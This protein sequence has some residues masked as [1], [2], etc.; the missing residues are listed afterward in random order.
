MET[1]FY[2]RYK[3]NNSP[4]YVFF[5]GGM[6]FARNGPHASVYNNRYL[7]LIK[8]QHVLQDRK[9]RLLLGSNIVSSIE[10]HKNIRSQARICH[11]AFPKWRNVFLKEIE[12]NAD[13]INSVTYS[14]YNFTKPQ[15]KERVPSFMRWAKR[16][17]SDKWSKMLIINSGVGNNHLI[18]DKFVLDEESN[19]DTSF[20]KYKTAVKVMIP[21][22]KESYDA[23]F[24]TAPFQQ[25]IK[26]E[27]LALSCKRSGMTEYSGLIY[28]W[29]KEQLNMEYLTRTECAAL[30][31]RLLKC[32]VSILLVQR[33]CGKTVAHIADAC[34]AIV[35]FPM[36]GY[37]FLY[38]A[39]DGNLVQNAFDTIKKVIWSMVAEFNDQER[40]NFLHI[41]QKV[42]KTRKVNN[43]NRMNMTNSDFYLQAKLKY[44]ISQHKVAIKFYRHDENRNQLDQDDIP[45]GE[46]WFKCRI[47]HQYK[48][49]FIYCTMYNYRACIELIVSDS[50]IH[51]QHSCAIAFILLCRTWVWIC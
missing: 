29:L 15:D 5:Q 8:E 16:F 19:D 24:N 45:Y 26:M 22:S 42:G 18:P 1:T 28:P 25:L 46:N 3:T 34:K 12:V 11:R 47:L 51:A 23:I 44:K 4:N 30:Y 31:E 40:S 2:P 13:T 50:L 37:K 39:H 38:L 41:K 6:G 7:G 17:V 48:V 36:A 20:H 35:T 10:R 9:R 14:K 43:N 32:Q 33:R 21:G 49:S 27:T